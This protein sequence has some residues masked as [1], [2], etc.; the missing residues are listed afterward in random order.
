M[1]LSRKFAAFVVDLTD[2]V[3]G[4]EPI[5]RRRSGPRPPPILKHP[6]HCLRGQ[7]Q[8]WRGETLGIAP[9]TRAHLR[10]L[11]D[12]RLNFRR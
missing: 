10:E 3:I 2:L 1:S 9:S 7:S 12:P 4:G 6:S 8:P 11:V 5:V